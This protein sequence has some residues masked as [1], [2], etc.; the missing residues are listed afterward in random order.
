MS[1]DGRCETGRK[2]VLPSPTDGQNFVCV[3][4]VCVCAR[5]SSAHAKSLTSV[6]RVKS[7]R[8]CR[9]GFR[10]RSSWC[11][12]RG[13]AGGAPS[14][15]WEGGY[16]LL[17]FFQSGYICRLVERRKRKNKKKKGKKEFFFFFSFL[18]HGVGAA[19]FSSLLRATTTHTTGI[20]TPKTRR[21]G[22][23]GL[24]TRKA[25]PTFFFPFFSSSSSFHLPKNPPSLL[26]TLCSTRMNFST[27]KLSDTHAHSI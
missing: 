14:K 2:T 9:L 25:R 11:L 19:L 6:E 15:K 3:L 24:V 1:D 23:P 21:G 27:E 16:I 18:Q 26:F 22:R 17:Y 4:C 12:E 5:R 10:C 13:W 20:Y 7:D 8:E